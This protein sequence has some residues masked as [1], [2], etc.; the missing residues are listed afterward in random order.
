MVVRMLIAALCAFSAQASFAAEPDCYDL[1]VKAKAIS[2]I[3]SVY[4][5]SDDPNVIIMSWPWF[6]D[7]KV[8]RVIEGDLSGNILK[9]L[10]VMHVR[11]VRKNLTWFLR[12]NAAGSFNV[13]RSDMP[14]ALVRCPSGVAP[15][16]PPITPA[17]GQSYAD[18][19][20]EG[21]AAYRR[22]GG[23]PE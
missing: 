6:V 10:A 4:P 22:L 19:R 23:D 3:P 11:Y 13:I 16:R 14:E 17:P 8:K 5:R 7:L 18:L 21:E 9:A 15:A 2:Q 12:R 1:K 20:K